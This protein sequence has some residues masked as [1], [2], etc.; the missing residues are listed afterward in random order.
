MSI[1]HSEKRILALLALPPSVWVSKLPVYA[2]DTVYLARA[3]KLC[4]QHPLFGCLFELWAQLDARALDRDDSEGRAL[5]RVRMLLKL[6]FDAGRVDHVCW[7]YGLDVQWDDYWALL[8]E[9]AKSFSPAESENLTL[10]LGSVLT[11]V[12]VRKLPKGTAF[13]DFKETWRTW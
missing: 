12:E 9:T 5:S 13:E 10:E 6:L 2:S 3:T 8:H 1:T 7:N 4:S 11:Q